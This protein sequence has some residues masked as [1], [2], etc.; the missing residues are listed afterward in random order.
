MVWL[1]PFILRRLIISRVVK[2]HV[3]TKYLEET[4]SLR[5]VL[6]PVSYEGSGSSCFTDFPVYKLITCI[7][8][9]LWKAAVLSNGFTETVLIGLFIVFIEVVFRPNCTPKEW[10]LSVIRVEMNLLDLDKFMT[11]PVSKNLQRWIRIQKFSRSSQR[12][13][14]MEVVEL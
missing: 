12:V 10:Q 4:E 6:Y 7:E 9:P 13:I 8:D 5:R 1:T 3:Y 2:L 11:E 14:I